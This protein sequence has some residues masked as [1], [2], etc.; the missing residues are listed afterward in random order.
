M[1]ITPLG[2]LPE[3]ELF[4]LAVSDREGRLFRD[5]GQHAVDGSC[6]YLGLSWLVGEANFAIEC[7][8]MNADHELHPT[9]TPGSCSVAGHARVIQSCADMHD[10]SL[11]PTD[12]RL[13]VALAVLCRRNDDARVSS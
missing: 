5:L 8:A 4:A 10:G 12:R 11:L 13:A 3:S 6:G 1:V 7:H 9:E 2:V